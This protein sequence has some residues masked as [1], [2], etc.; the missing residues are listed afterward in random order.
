MMASYQGGQGEA[1]AL[2]WAR[3]LRAVPAVPAHLALTQRH[4][5]MDT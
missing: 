4:I 2:R 5:H 1:R 3:A